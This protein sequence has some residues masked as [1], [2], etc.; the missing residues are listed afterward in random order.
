MERIEIQSVEEKKTKKGARYLAV[1]TNQGKM[2]VF[3]KKLHGVIYCGVGMG[4][5]EMNGDFKNLVS[6]IPDVP[7]EEAARPTSQPVVPP[8]VDVRKSAT[9]P[10]GPTVSY[11]DKK[12]SHIVAQSAVN[13]A[14]SM[15]EAIYAKDSE[16]AP[17]ELVRFW[18]DLY[19]SFYR[20]NV[21]KLYT[22]G[23]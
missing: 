4:T 2:S 8:V 16:I 22:G 6:W 13:A 18:N 11:E 21:K 15:V 9:V 1:E 20:D 14:F 3:D 19:L 7:V 12:N 17:T 23:E 5:I 10:S